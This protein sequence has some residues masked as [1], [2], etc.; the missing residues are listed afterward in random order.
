M[1]ER[2]R[3]NGIAA[4]VQAVAEALEERERAQWL[5]CPEFGRYVTAAEE[6]TDNLVFTLRVHR[7]LALGGQIR[8]GMP[9]AEFNEGTP[10]K[11]AETIAWSV[12]CF[13]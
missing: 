13:T 2:I 10:Q 6:T 5:I 8:F 9:W 11:I 3:T 7:G 4:K 1:R 12:Q